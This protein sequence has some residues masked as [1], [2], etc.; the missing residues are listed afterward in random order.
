[1]FTK[2]IRVKI[3]LADAC[4]LTDFHELDLIDGLFG[5]DLQ[6]IISAE[7]FADLPTV[8]QS[9]FSIPPYSLKLQVIELEEN[10]SAALYQCALPVQFSH[11]DKAGFHLARSQELPI[12]SSD[13]CTWRYPK[14]HGINSCGFFWILDQLVNAGLIEKSTACEKL[15]CWLAMAAFRLDLADLGKEVQE[16]LKKWDYPIE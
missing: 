8:L 14:V 4:L 1:M 13:P 5:L 2:T 9:S 7:L 12:L 6:L 3:V 11:T 10:G 15:Q 16:R